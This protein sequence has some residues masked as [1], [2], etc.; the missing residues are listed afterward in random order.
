[1]VIRCCL[2]IPIKCAMFLSDSN[3]PFLAPFP[4]L[5]SC[6][7]IL[8]SGGPQFLR[9]MLWEHSFQRRLPSPL[10]N[11]TWRLSS[12]LTV[13]LVVVEL[14]SGGKMCSLRVPYCIPR[15]V[16]RGSPRLLPVHLRTSTSSRGPSPDMKMRSACAPLPNLCP[17]LH[18]TL[19]RPSSF[20]LQHVEGQRDLSSASAS[21]LIFIW[22]LCLELCA[23]SC[24]QSR[25]W[26][27]QIKWLELARP[28]LDLVTSSPYNSSLS[29][30]KTRFAVL[31][32]LWHWLVILV[33]FACLYIP[34][35]CYL[36]N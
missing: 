25:Y 4:R 28:Q 9:T 33:S 17:H 11:H 22:P 24:R 8:T 32:N 15:G 30:K 2:T 3:P 13:S 29:F 26:Y 27:I 18:S 21:W 16:R 35:E 10:S 14:Q 20:N 19:H 5:P 7:F 1:M 36:T 23:L 12:I 34:C 31:G 6:Y